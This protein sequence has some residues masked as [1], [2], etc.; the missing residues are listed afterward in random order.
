MEHHEDQRIRLVYQSQ[1]K[2][3][4]HPMGTFLGETV[5][6]FYPFLGKYGW[7]KCQCSTMLEFY[8][9]RDFVFHPLVC[10]FLEGR[11]CVIFV[12]ISTC[13]LHNGGQLIFVE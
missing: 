5:M 2:M 3:P 7:P 11:N 12:F 10:D 6:K 13:L 8:N 9:Y 1:G 4:T